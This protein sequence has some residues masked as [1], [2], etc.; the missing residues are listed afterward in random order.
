VRARVASEALGSLGSLPN[1]GLVAAAWWSLP[2]LKPRLRR[3]SKLCA[4]VCRNGQYFGTVLYS[5]IQ[6]DVV[7]VSDCATQN[8]RRQRP[9]VMKSERLGSLKMFLMM[10]WFAS[11]GLVG[12][13]RRDGGVFWAGGWHL[14]GRLEMAGAA[15]NEGKHVPTISS[16]EAHP[17]VCHRVRNT[18]YS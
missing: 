11:H 8:G 13:G 17:E 18:K 6:W 14:L 7:L 1:R 9:L 12:G 10:A 4:V 5:T 16:M 3:S 2:V 15:T